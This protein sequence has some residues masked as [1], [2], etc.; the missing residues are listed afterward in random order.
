MSA[1]ISKPEPA[2]GSAR[3]IAAV[4]L[5]GGLG[6]RMGRWKGGLWWEGRRTLLEAHIQRARDIKAEPILVTVPTVAMPQAQHL[7][8]GAKVVEITDSQTP[9]LA[10]LQMALRQAL[11]QRPDI[12]F[13]YVTPVDWPPLAP[14][15]IDGLFHVAR[16]SKAVATRPCMGT[17]EGTLKNGHPVFLHKQAFEA[18]LQLDPGKDRLDH[19]LRDQP[20]DKQRGY[21][22]MDP[23]RYIDMNTPE[24]YAQAKKL[25][26]L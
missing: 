17:P 19:W 6:T 9:Q 26:G 21:A 10:S 5:A 14:D 3:A 24:E 2:P 13:L 25:L 12:A 11:S 7:V 16:K 23:A 4:I 1:A 18:V 20:L 15:D 8:R 22:L